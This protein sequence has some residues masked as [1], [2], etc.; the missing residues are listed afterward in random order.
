M[1]DSISIFSSL[2]ADEHS[3]AF[4]RNLSK[5]LIQLKIFILS[6]CQDREKEVI[7]VIYISFSLVSM[8]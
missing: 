8:V 3:S 1:T 2:F 4:T 7:V 5:R 6:K